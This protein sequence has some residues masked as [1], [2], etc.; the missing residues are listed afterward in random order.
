[1]DF[2][3]TFIQILFFGLYLVAPLILFICLFIVVLGLIVGRI[4]GWSKFDAVYWS[5]ITA[6]TVGFG[7][8]RPLRKRA[9]TLAVAITLAGIMFSGIIVS[10]T[11]RAALEA[12]KIHA[13]TQVI[14]KM[15]DRVK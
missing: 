5:F 13:D 11:V 7:D 10:V 3:F 4:E 6:L 2:T 12:F 14:Q 8:I 1:M 9:K 15:Q